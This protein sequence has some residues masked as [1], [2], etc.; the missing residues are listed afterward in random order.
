MLSPNDSIKYDDLIDGLAYHEQET[1]SESNQK[2]KRRQKANKKNQNV[3]DQIFGADS[4]NTGDSSSAAPTD[5]IDDVA[6]SKK[7]IDSIKQ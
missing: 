7:E 4:K 6:I 2:D 1:N 5:F 3:Q